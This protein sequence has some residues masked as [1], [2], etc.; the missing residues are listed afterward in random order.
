MSVAVR[1][2]ADL[3]GSGEATVRLACVEDFHAALACNR[4]MMGERY[5]RCAAVTACRI[6]VQLT[7]SASQ[8]EVFENK[9]V[10]ANEEEATSSKKCESFDSF[11]SLLSFDPL[12]CFS[13]RVSTVKTPPRPPPPPRVSAAAT[14]VSSEESG[15]V[16]ASLLKGVK[17]K[18]S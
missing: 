12:L 17:L 18:T 9:K 10:R 16:R 2:A 7:D 8:I 14:T 1:F 3:R 13:L 5:V 6:Q 4:N 15:N 11:S